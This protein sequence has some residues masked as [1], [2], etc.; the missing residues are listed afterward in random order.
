[1]YG[2]LCGLRPHNEAK[3]GQACARPYPPE[4]HFFFS[5]EKEKTVYF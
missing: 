2:R 3:Y 1:M 4:I 5:I